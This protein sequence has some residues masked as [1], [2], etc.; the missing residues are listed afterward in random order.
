MKKTVAR[1][2]GDAML[3]AIYIVLSTLTVRI[4]PNLQITFTGI[5]II[6]A[7]VLYGFPVAIFVAL[8]G[9]FLAQLSGPYGISIT[10]PI[11]MIPPI[12]RAVVFGLIYDLYL[13]KGIKLED[14]RWLYITFAILAGL[15]TTIANTGAIYLDAIIW[16][17][18]VSMA[19][20]ESVFRFLSSIASSIFIAL[21]SLPIIYALRNAGLIRNRIKEENKNSSNTES[22]IS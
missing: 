4:T 3:L 18:P 10:T 9:S 7:S 19:I 17:Y 13:K 20:V 2:C 14:K 22:V 6:M 5:A 12:L 11:W 1:I 21:I 15:V 8:F 16:Q